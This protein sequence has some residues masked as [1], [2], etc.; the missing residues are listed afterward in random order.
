MSPR[1]SGDPSE[2]RTP[3]TLIK[4]SDLLKKQSGL[5][6]SKRRHLGTTIAQGAP[7]RRGSQAATGRR[8]EI[9]AHDGK[10]A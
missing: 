8:C 1:P 7:D 4:S 6:L 5:N 9:V 2:I 3:D 10:R